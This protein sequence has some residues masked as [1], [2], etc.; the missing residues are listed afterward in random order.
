MAI[1]GKIHPEL[2]PKFWENEILP[3][4]GL[5]WQSGDAEA[6]RLVERLWQGHTLKGMLISAITDRSA[7]A[8]VK[9][10]K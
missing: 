1:C 8:L 10:S 3:V 2:P 9:R 5:Y 6:E 7:S 4:V